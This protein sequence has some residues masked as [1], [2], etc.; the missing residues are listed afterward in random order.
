MSGTHH[1]VHCSKKQNQQSTC[2]AKEKQWIL[3]SK[4]KKKNKMTSKTNLAYMA[5]GKFDISHHQKQSVHGGEVQEV[6]MLFLEL[7]VIPT[8]VVACGKISPLLHINNNNKIL[9]ANKRRKTK[10]R[11]KPHAVLFASSGH[12]IVMH[13]S[14]LAL[15][16]AKPTSLQEPI[17][18]SSSPMPYDMCVKSK[19]LFIP[20]F[21]HQLLGVSAVVQLLC[22]LVGLWPRAQMDSNSNTP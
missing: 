21:T 11:N 5:L 13:N 7:T 18:E 17:G 4:Q 9:I 20:L 16:P 15:V 6:I 14:M 3:H 12:V 2:E 19:H 1:L 22:L 8:C 10:T